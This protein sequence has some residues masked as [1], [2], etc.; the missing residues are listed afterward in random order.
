MKAYGGV[1]VASLILKFGIGWK[2]VFSFM[3]WFIYTPN[4]ASELVSML[5]TRANLLPLPG[6]Q[7]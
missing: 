6:V 2:S 5:L 7:P 3:S 4:R 1:E